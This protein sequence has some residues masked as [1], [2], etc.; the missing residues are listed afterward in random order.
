[1]HRKQL[2]QFI[3]AAMHRQEVKIRCYAVPLT[4]IIAI[5]LVATPTALLTWN[6]RSNSSN[7]SE[8]VE[9]PTVWFDV[10]V[11][12]RAGNDG[13]ADGE[14]LR[15]EAPAAEPRP[16]P[17]SDDVG[18]DPAG[19]PNPLQRGKMPPSDAKNGSVLLRSVSG[20]VPRGEGDAGGEG[21]GDD[22]QGGL[23]NLAGSAGEAEPPDPRHYRRRH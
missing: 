3:R 1:M 8:P 18:Q 15:S 22:S 17:R 2:D 19:P 13:P 11:I 12:S 21:S 6:L 20:Q 4:F 23:V 10:Q 5:P 9:K 7:S 16:I 14:E